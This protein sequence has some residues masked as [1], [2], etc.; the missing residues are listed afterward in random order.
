MLGNGTHKDLKVIFV[1]LK[2]HDA[3]AECSEEPSQLTTR[4]PN[5]PR[6]YIAHDTKAEFCGVLLQKTVLFCFSFLFYVKIRCFV[7]R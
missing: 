6:T 7:K 4:R 5:V 2:A 3:K 1:S